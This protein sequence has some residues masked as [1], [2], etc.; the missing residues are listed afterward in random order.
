MRWI[1]RDLG[2]NTYVNV[3]SQYFPAGK[4]SRME[5]AHPTEEQDETAACEIG[6]RI[7]DDEFLDALVAAREAWLWRLDAR[8]VAA[9]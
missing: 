4:V 1:V 9:L 8:S 7:T 6:R 3:M 2:A 5:Y